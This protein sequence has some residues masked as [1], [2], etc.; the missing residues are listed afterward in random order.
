MAGVNVSS[1]TIRKQIAELKRATEEIAAARQSI[2]QQYQQLSFGWNDS[3]SR[4]LGAIVSEA[5]TALRNIEKVLLQ[6]Q[7]SLALLLKE[8]EDYES[9][10]I[11]PNGGGADQASVLS[12]HLSPEEVNHR[13]ESAVRSIDERIA[14]YRDGLHARGVPDC[15]W[16]NA[17]LAKHRANMLEQSGYE[18]DVASGHAAS[19][20]HNGNAYQYPGDYVA[21]YDQLAADFRTYCSR[22]ANPNYNPDRMDKWRVNCQRC[23]PTYELLRRGENVT[24]LP[25][26]SANDY[27]ATAPFAVW[28]NPTVIRCAGNGQSEIESAMQNWGDGA[29]AQ[30]TV[31]WTETQGHV[32]I[33]EQRDGRTHYID[34]QSG[35]EDYVEWTYSAMPDRTRFCRIDNLEPTDW[36][37]NCYREIDQ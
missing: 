13:W 26:E 3:K 29:R 23:V 17:L 37:R 7:K 31:M 18:L 33:A 11:T 4:E 1:E 14:N 24:A 35:N 12:L 15:V 22:A 25:R 32:F 5:N 8:I 21:F 6:G 10:N 30:V 19:T 27:L 2:T 16:L 36:I 34:P 20:V 9:L 28:N